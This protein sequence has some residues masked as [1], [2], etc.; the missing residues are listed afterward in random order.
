VPAPTMCCF[1]GP[2]LRSLVVT[3]HRTGAVVKQLGQYPES[4]G[5]FIARAPV[6]GSPVPRMPL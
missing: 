2:D 3:S 6:A 4:G 1:C 5:L